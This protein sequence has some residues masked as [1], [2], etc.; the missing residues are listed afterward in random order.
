ML[1]MLAARGGFI[2]LAAGGGYLAGMGINKGLG[3]IMNISTS[4]RYSGDG[5]I[6][7]M[8]YDMLHGGI[9]GRKDQPKNDIK[10]DVHFDGS[11]RV[12]TN[13]NSMNTTVNTGGN[14]G[15]FWDDLAPARG[16]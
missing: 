2:G 5:A 3:G 11:G 9:Q 14:R 15:S 1:P 12:W 16:M 4:G 13:T 6:G 10:V 7:E 8:L